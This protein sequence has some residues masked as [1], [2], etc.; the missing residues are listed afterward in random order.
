MTA[1][2][3]D[4]ALVAEKAYQLWLAEGQ[5]DGK[6]DEHWFRAIDALTAPVA[7]KPR[8]TAAAKPAAKATATP[9]APR[10]PKADA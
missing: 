4:E 3:F 1:P 7:K 2:A 9:R 10:K 8:R 6:S 5:P